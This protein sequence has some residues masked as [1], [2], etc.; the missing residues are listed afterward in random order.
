MYVFRLIFVV[1]WNIPR[2]EQALGPLTCHAK[3]LAKLLLSSCLAGFKSCSYSLWP[4]FEI[5]QAATELDEASKLLQ[6]LY[7]QVLES[8][9]EK[10]HYGNTVEYVV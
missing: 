7:Y 2:V 6:V 5:R 8:G 9:G 4:A 10:H 1:F 3:M